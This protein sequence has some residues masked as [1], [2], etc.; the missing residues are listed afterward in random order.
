MR[1][2]ILSIVALCISVSASAQSS[3]QNMQLNSLMEW[4]ANGNRYGL[5][6]EYNV[7]LL[8]SKKGGYQ[9]FAGA[10]DEFFIKDE[11]DIEGITGNTFSNVLGA[12]VTNGFHFL[13][14]KKLYFYHT[15][16][17]GWGFRQ[18]DAN[19]TNPTYQIDRDYESE[20]HYF[21]LGAYWKLGYMVSDRIGIQAIGKTDF[22]RLVDQYEP[23]VFER[24]GFMMGLGVLYAFK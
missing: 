18:T 5:G 8:E 7:S 14:N 3:S 13:N 15:I 4:S 21:A 20:S 16:Y 2:L 11:R 12:S 6:L 24:P 9:L 19:Y 17:A 22:S 23:T 10:F 1:I